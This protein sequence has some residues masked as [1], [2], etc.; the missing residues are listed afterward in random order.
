MT[1]SKT[2]TW[3]I[4]RTVRADLRYQWASRYFLYTLVC[5]MAV[6]SAFAVG[7]YATAHS[8]VNS[9]RQEWAFLHQDGGYTFE[10]A[11]G[12]GSDPTDDPL[13]ETW[14]SAGQAVANL[15]PFQGTVN[16]LQ[17]LCF[18]I[19]PL[20]FFTYGAIAPTRDTHYKTLKFRAVREGP[21][22]LFLS[23]AVTLTAAVTALTAAAFVATLLTST[24]LHLAV[25]GRVDTRL[26]E[27]PGDLSPADTLPTLAMTLTTG[28]VF[29][30]LGMSAALIVRRPLY[31]LPVFLVGFFLVPILGRFDPR[32]LLMAIA[33]P[34]LEFVGG[35]IPPA[36]APVSELAAAA[37][38]TV[39]TAVVL[40]I[41]YAVH[42]RRSL[43][44]T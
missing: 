38:L 28:V 33:Y 30:L 12:R 3:P 37:L 5:F 10:R 9:L 25:N 19:G 42:S 18:V 24:A 44:T 43:C 16:L 13:K 34:H 15:H 1:V 17:V 14:E 31:V 32:N 41:T 36:P 27:V 29:A 39:G 11:I 22:R 4:T 7:A 2:R 23:Q 6:A 40:A 26:L 21:R 35:F 20:V 8:A